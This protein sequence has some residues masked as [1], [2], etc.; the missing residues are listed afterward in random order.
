MWMSPNTT[1][2]LIWHKAGTI[3]PFFVAAVLNFALVYS[4]NSFA[5][6]KKCYLLLYLPA[7]AFWL[8]DLFTEA[9]NTAPILEYW[10][11]NDIASG[12]WVYGLSTF[13]TAL[14]PL[15]AFGVC[16]R[17]YLR[18]KENTEKSTALNVTIGFAI[19][20]IS[21][22][23]T[24]M[25]AR[26]LDIGIP[27]LG[28][29]STLF[30]VVFVG[31][32]IVKYGLFTLNTRLAA[33]NIVSTMPD[34]LILANMS[35]N[36]IKVN[37]RLVEFSGYSEKELMHKSIGKLFVADQ[38]K[39]NSAYRDLIQNRIIR[40]VELTLKTKTSKER[41]VFFSGSIVQAK[42]NRPIGLTCVIHDIT[43]RKK[44][45]EDLTNTKNYLE[46]LL[47]SM[48]SAIVVID[49]KTHEIVDLN[50]AALKMLEATQEEVL[51]K[52]CHNFV[53]Q[54]QNSKCPITDLGQE[55]DNQEKVLYTLKGKKKFIIKNV[56]KLQIND[57]LLLL[58]NFIDVSQRKAMEEKL[59]KA[60]RLASIGELA[61][62][63]GHDLRN[64][65]A[66]I[67]NGVY[68]VKK[69]GNQI[70]QKQRAEILSVI[71]TAVED[72]NRIVT[73][74]IDFAMEPRL[75]TQSCTPKSLVAAALSKLKIPQNITVKN[76]VEEDSECFVD[77]G[78]MIDVF[79]RILQNSIHAIETQGEIQ[80]Q[81]C[82]KDG[83]VTVTFEDTGCGI[84][85]EVLPKLFTPLVTTKAKGMGL[86][87]AIC[88]RI[89]EAHGG[90]ITAEN[91]ERTGAKLSVTLPIAPKLEV[92]STLMV[93]T[94]FL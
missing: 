16:L 61:G 21:F 26:A 19:P 22:I 54:T 41:I 18:V 28:P 84:P 1:E 45:E 38:E 64:P 82:L 20:I 85:K 2:A 36:I 31:Y 70:T 56:A 11:Y 63:L 34:S 40:N 9:I 30:F 55:I 24:N 6:S 47:D 46:T 23:A 78:R 50:N 86:G 12:T 33:E 42:G 66:G 91:K 71:E 88:K 7:A 13:W 92:A 15:L 52:L 62:Q 17:Y 14:L 48:L 57:R 58:E 4:N 5:R 27:N 44:A 25:L 83:Y 67:K 69:K 39:W 75:E 29:I 43:E 68:L 53:C 37:E 74:L 32:A 60:Q 89:V 87:L 72:S 90:K 81:S 35:A 8:V 76:L 49:G 80:I 77:I 94:D 93:Q 73:S 51:G 79:A 10:G 3:W 59:F 65:L